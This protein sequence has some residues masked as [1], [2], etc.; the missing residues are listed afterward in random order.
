MIDSFITMSL[1]SAAGTVVIYTGTNGYDSDKK[2]ANER[3]TVG[4]EYVVASMDVG[5]SSSTV[6]F[7]GV[8]GNFNTVMFKNRDE[9]FETYDWFSDNYPTYAKIQEW[10]AEGKIPAPVPV[11]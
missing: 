8:D 2:Y 3:L 1:E 7:E 10:I 4:N 5:R 9:E 6:K 11:E